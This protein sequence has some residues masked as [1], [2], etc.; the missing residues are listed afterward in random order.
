MQIQKR[1]GKLEKFNPHKI[2]K[3][4]E[5][6]FY[7]LW[8]NKNSAE[9][10][11][12]KILSS[13][14]E[15][16]KTFEEQNISLDVETIQDLVEQSLADNEHYQ[17]LISYSKYRKE[18][19]KI[20]EFIKNIPDELKDLYHSTEEYFKTPIQI[21]QY[22]DKYS[23]YDWNLL[24]RETWRETISQR[25]IPFYIE[26]SKGKLPNEMYEELDRAILNVWA[27]PSMRAI[28]TAG[29]AARRDNVCIYNCSFVAVDDFEAFVE[30][31]HISMCGCG[32]GFSVESHYVNKL[33][34]IRFQSGKTTKFTIKDSTEGWGN[35]LRFGLNSWAN[36]DDIQFDFSELREAGTILKT[37][38]GRASGPEPL[39]FSLNEIRKIFLNAQGRQLFSWECLLI[40][41]LCGHCAVSGGVR[42]TAMICIS[43]MDDYAIADIKTGD[44]YKKYPYL[45]NANI[46]ASFV[47]NYSEEEISKY[48]NDM[49]RS[50]MGER[51]IFSPINAIK[52]A[53]ERRKRL[54]EQELG[55][56]ITDDIDT[57]L[58]AARILKIGSNPCGEINL[59]TFCNL[60]VNVLDKKDTWEDILYK[61]RIATILGTIQA[62][63]TYF[64]NLRPFWTEITERE[65]LLGV[66]LLGLADIGYLS[67]EKLK[68]LKDYTVQVNI[69]ISK[70]LGTNPSSATT[71]NKPGGNTGV[72]T[73]KA[74]TISKWKYS[75]FIRNV[76]V[77]IR[78]PMFKVLTWSKVPGFPKPFSE[79]SSYI[80]SFPERAPEESLVQD[81]DTLEDQL[82]MWKTVKINYTE[83]NPSCTLYYKEHELNILKK[84]IYNNQ[85]VIGGL[86]F[87]ENIDLSKLNLQYLPVQKISEEEYYDR[88]KVFP[89]INWEILA[90]IEKEDATTSTK[91]FACSG[92]K[93]ELI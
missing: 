39:K 70:I 49:H 55:F 26:L 8:H 75:F 80:F 38:G 76:E 23:R 1:D 52:N 90:E 83:H 78:S 17:A 92:D 66:D 24:R 37:K 21:F 40:M 12:D 46:S 33:P 51:G 28:A 10:I 65:R 60:S 69:E 86:T 84:W 54:W 53:P 89:K 73:R 35:A 57:L 15:K 32:V 16:I 7:H 25:L 64:P 2:K 31:L 19:T 71:A 44:W 43:D 62:Q 41:C 48:V 85:D 42:R 72:L 56:N 3:A 63:A 18:R 91:E 81:N 59:R 82:E 20:R 6:C 29:P 5:K 87:L 68:Y 27:L 45:S 4:I 9:T 14:L 93:C 47:R 67:A 58:Q 50:K 77:D 88:I 79:Q 34:Y 30:A 13:T 61:Q 36:G 11:S 74:S 22:Y